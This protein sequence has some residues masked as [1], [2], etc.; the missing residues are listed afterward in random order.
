VSTEHPYRVGLTGGIGSGKSTVAELFAARG[1]HVIDADEI[2]HRLS[3]PNGAAVAALRDAFGAQFITADGG[4]DRVRMRQLVFSNDAARRQLEGILH[5]LIRAETDRQML[6][7]GASYVMLVIPLLFESKGWKRRVERALVVDCPE[8]LQIARVMR[9]S[10]LSRAEVEAIMSRQVG[11]AERLRQA[12]DV[13]DNS[14]Q[15]EALPTAVD[16]LHQL[17]LVGARTARL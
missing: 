9:R 13:I 14:G 12:D 7:G 15:P 10:K 8:E 5:P 3:E 11:R 17:Y 2:A 16:R 1:A 6:I 4:L